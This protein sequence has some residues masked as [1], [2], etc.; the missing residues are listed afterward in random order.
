MCPDKMSLRWR[1]SQ[2]WAWEGAKQG[3]PVGG[4]PSW[5][6]RACAEPMCEEQPRAEDPGQG[7]GEGLAVRVAVGLYF[8]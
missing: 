3:R 5:R 1:L 2:A 6:P 7:H 4:Q 8:V